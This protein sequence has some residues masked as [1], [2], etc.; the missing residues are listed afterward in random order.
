[1]RVL[2]LGT[3]TGTVARTL[4]EAGAEVLGIDPAPGQVAAARKLAEEEG[5]GDRAHFEE[6]LAERTGQEDAAFDLV[7]AAQCWHWFD[8]GLAAAEAKRVLK[9]AARC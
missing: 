7:V 9:P 2:D 8:R 1:M 6:G 4:A 3:G 5:I